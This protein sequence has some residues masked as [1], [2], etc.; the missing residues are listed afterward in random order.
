MLMS[1]REKC[2]ELTTA[3]D[4]KRNL[5]IVLISGLAG[6]HPAAELENRSGLF[7]MRDLLLSRYNRTCY[8]LCSVY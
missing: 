5:V 6:N 4:C 1:E 7:L 8:L 2:D 3:D